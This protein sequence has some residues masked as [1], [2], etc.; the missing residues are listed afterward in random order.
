[1]EHEFITHQLLES[2]RPATS[3]DHTRGISF[4]ASVLLPARARLNRRRVT[5]D[6]LARMAGIRRP[7][8]RSDPV[9]FR[10]TDFGS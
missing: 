3:S 8:L 1:V 9:H 2:Q 6:R 10:L 5:I 7:A 4:D